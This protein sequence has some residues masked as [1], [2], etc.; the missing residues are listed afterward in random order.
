MHSLWGHRTHGSAGQ[1]PRRWSWTLWGYDAR[2]C[3]RAAFALPPVAAILAVVTAAVVDV[4]WHQLVAGT[5]FP[6]LAVMP[7]ASVVTAEPAPELH[8]SVPHPY[9][10]TIARRLAVAGGL[11]TA[12]AVLAALTTGLIEP[13][14]HVGR[15]FTLAWCSSVLLVGAGAAG[16]AALRSAAGASAVVVGVWL[17]QVLILERLLGDGGARLVVPVLVGTTATIWALIRFRTAGVPGADRR[18]E[19]AP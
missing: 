4:S 10:R 6:I 17:G 19:V 18:T 5:L 14:T 12:G 3:G 7:A 11:V 2:H 15:F 16:G 1:A 9:P 13:T 8:A